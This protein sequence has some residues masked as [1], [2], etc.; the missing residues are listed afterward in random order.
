MLVVFMD[1]Q[2]YVICFDKSPHLIDEDI[3]CRGCCGCHLVA[4]LPWQMQL[5]VAI[6]QCDGDVKIL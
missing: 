2:K 1:V 4:V 3:R 6:S 5:Y